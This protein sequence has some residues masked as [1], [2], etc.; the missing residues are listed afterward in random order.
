MQH[1]CFR[2]SRRLAISAAFSSLLIPAIPP[3]TTV[4]EDADGDAG[5]LSSKLSSHPPGTVI[6]ADGRGGAGG[7]GRGCVAGCGGGA[8]LL[9]ADSAGRCWGT[10]SR[11]AGAPRARPTNR[12]GGEPVE[13]AESVGDKALLATSG[14][15]SVLSWSR[16]SP[17]ASSR[18][19]GGGPLWNAPSEIRH[20][21]SNQIEI[22]TRNQNF[23]PVV[24][25]R[26][27]VHEVRVLVPFAEFSRSLF[28]QLGPER[29]L[30]KWL[31]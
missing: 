1:T 14:V 24:R 10:I 17:H 26:I 16:L 18:S 7:D 29:R 22:N 3:A 19:I 12:G 30:P 15:A 9:G 27:D 25:I 13:R 21:V 31:L 23:T 8:G 20:T 6:G 2:S 5:M 11:A 28:L 4:E